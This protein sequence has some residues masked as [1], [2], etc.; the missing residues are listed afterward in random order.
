MFNILTTTKIWV[1]LFAFFPDFMR[2]VLPILQNLRNKRS[3]TL[4]STLLTT[5]WV[6]GKQRLFSR[7]RTKVGATLPSYAQSSRHRPDGNTQTWKIVDASTQLTLNVLKNAPT[8]FELTPE[9][10][11]LSI[12]A[13]SPHPALVKNCESLDTRARRRNAAKGSRGC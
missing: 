9:Q 8:I 3:C 13:L 6:R 5:R 7:A 1:S 11:K 4:F 10:R 2:G 12:R